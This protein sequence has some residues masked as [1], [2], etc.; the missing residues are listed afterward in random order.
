MKHY[1]A[2]GSNLSFEQMRERCP[3]HRKIGKGTLEGYKWFLSSRGYANVINSP[4]ERVHGF[5]YGISEEDER[6]LDRFEGVHQGLYRK[7]TLPVRLDE[8]G[9]LECLVYIDSASPASGETVLKEWYKQRINRGIEDA[10]LP[11]EYVRNVIRRFV[12]AEAKSEGGLPS[13]TMEGLKVL[14]K[15]LGCE[16]LPM[17]R[18]WGGAGLIVTR[19]EPE[20]PGNDWRFVRYAGTPHAREVSWFIER[21]RDAFYTEERVDN[22]SKYEF[23]GRLGNAA[24]RCGE[25]V[26]NADARMLCASVLREA[27]AMY[28][29]M[30]QG[31]FL[32]LGIASGGDIADDFA[33]RDFSEKEIRAFFENRGVDASVWKR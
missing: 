12:P 9:C 28:E 15:V 30:E 4:E 26:E 19:G 17:A 16:R 6:N 29:E 32:C 13:T 1:F 7:E 20:K 25:S 31:R 8:G 3:E 21:I 18:E 14:E 23:F 10:E 22:C 33:E 27:Y 11:P 2:Y 5:V 24:G